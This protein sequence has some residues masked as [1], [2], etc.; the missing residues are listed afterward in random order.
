MA[1]D[2]NPPHSHLLLWPV[3]GLPTNVAYSIWIGIS[4]ALLVTATLYLWPPGGDWRVPLIV[5]ALF[6]GAPA[7]TLVLTGQVSVIRRPAAVSCLAG[8]QGWT[9]GGWPVP[10]SASS[11]RSNQLSGP[12]CC[13]GSIG[14]N[15]KRSAESLLR[16][17]RDAACPQ[18][19]SVFQISRPGRGS[20]ARFHGPGSR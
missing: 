18:Q 16:R 11:W 17:S 10:G 8:G 1:R 5:I 12:S 20:W 6:T 14:A 13:G 15:G 4:L 9:A 2:L 19:S 3:C 7:S